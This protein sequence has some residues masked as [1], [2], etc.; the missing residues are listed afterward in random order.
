MR[1]KIKTLGLALVAVLAMSALAASAASAGVTEIE[2]GTSATLHGEQLENS[3]VFTLTDNSNL[4]TTC[5][6]ATFSA[7]GET[8]NGIST[9]ELHPEYSECTAFAGLS[10]TVN[11]TG[12]NYLVHAGEETAA[13]EF[14]ASVDVNCE[15]GKEITI[16]AGTC[17]L[18]VHKT[19]FLLLLRITNSGGGGNL[20]DLLLHMNVVKITYTITKDGFLCPLSGLGEFKEGD[21]TGTAT[22]RA[23]RGGKQVGITMKK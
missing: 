11:T 14:D 5:K 15:A 7:V 3:H 23:F 22:V 9:A 18:K 19:L 6:V 21:Y 12:C 4:T 17:E 13:G 8:A 10:A 1:N 16:T 2:G 20:M